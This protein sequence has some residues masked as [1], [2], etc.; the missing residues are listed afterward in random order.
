M[1]YLLDTHT[2][3]WA[4]SEQAK[5][6]VKAKQ[7]ID[8]SNNSIFVS[9]ITF[10]EIALKFSINKFGIEGTSP[11]VLPEIAVTMGFQLIQLS[12]EESASS[13]K[14]TLSPHKDPFD[15]ILIWQAIKRDYTF[16]SKDARI[17]E[18]KNDGLKILW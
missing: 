18:H 1:N 11:D 16:I 9:S 2:F 15:R 17:N 13:H 10:W 4:I 5:L 14:L 12:P 8:N 3:I 6:S 7:A